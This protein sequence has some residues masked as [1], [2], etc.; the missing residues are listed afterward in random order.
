MCYESVP[1][2]CVMLPSSFTSSLFARD[3]KSAL[4]SSGRVLQP[5]GERSAHGQ[6]LT[7]LRGGERSARGQGLTF[8]K[9][10]ERL[11]LSHGLS[12]EEPGDNA[13][14]YTTQLINQNED[15]YAAFERSLADFKERQAHTAAGAGGLQFPRDARQSAKFG[16]PKEGSQQVDVLSDQFQRVRLGN[17]SKDEVSFS[18][19]EMVEQSRKASNEMIRTTAGLRAIIEQLQVENTELLAKMANSNE[20]VQAEKVMCERVCTAME[21]HRT[22]GKKA[23]TKQFVVCIAEIVEEF[24]KE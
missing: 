3:D 13:S 6:G 15:A 11:S 16:S 17:E 24:Q 9:D 7:F 5:T 23:D 12:F 21:A 18:V 2:I 1:R 20:L 14:V 10:A 8:L 4:L 19:Q 22:A